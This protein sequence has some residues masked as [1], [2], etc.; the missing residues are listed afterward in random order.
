MAKFEIFAGLGGSFGGAQS[1]GIY[2]YETKEEAVKDA[3]QLAVEEYES[4]GGCHGLMDWD[5]CKED[6][7]EFF[8]EGIT[9]E[10]V[11]MHYQE[12]M[13]SW[14]SYYAVEIH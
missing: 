3:Y 14:L 8:G 10:D 12:E 4:Y 2:E 11:S 7:I 13:E 1:H 6:L 5:M 9:D